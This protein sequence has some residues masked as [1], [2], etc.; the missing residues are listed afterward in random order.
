M[1]ADEWPRLRGGHLEDLRH[2]S[3][4]NDAESQFEIPYV[5]SFAAARGRPAAR[6]TFE[7][8]VLVH[9]H[10]GEPAAPAGDRRLGRPTGVP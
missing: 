7:T 10:E 2:Q 1:L 5:V 9:D 3:R 4:W 8:T 6:F